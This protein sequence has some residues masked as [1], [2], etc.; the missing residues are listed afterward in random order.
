MICGCVASFER[1]YDGMWARRGGGKLGQGAPLRGTQHEG[2]SNDAELA[3]L[4]RKVAELAAELEVM[5]CCLCAHAWV[6]V[7]LLMIWNSCA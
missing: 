4:Q 6:K 5:P 1:L 3:R 7:L 2:W